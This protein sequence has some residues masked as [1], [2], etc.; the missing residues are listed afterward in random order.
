MKK[1][2]WIAATVGA[3]VVLGGGGY[4]LGTMNNGDEPPVE[5][6]DIVTSSSPA[7]SDAPAPAASADPV[8]A[9]TPTP[10]ESVDPGLELTEAEQIFLPWA[11]ENYEFY[12]STTSTLLAMSDQD[13][14]D[15]LHQACEVG[16]DRAAGLVVIPGFASEDDLD[17]DT[18]EDEANRLFIDAARLGYGPGVTGTAGS[19]CG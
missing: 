9:V 6:A 16:G 2:G 11:R 14:L 3:V 4:A 10:V 7:P 15:A 13:M 17:P 1:T 8:E 19:Y 5:T 12:R 18:S